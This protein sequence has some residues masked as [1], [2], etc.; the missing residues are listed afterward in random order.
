MAGE[1]VVVSERSARRCV[2]RSLATH[3]DGSHLLF[4]AADGTGTAGK[5][6]LWR[7]DGRKVGGKDPDLMAGPGCVF[8][9]VWS[10]WSNP[11][12]WRSL[13]RQRDSEGPGEIEYN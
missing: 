3:P 8:H 11:V 7:F 6:G 1:W 12:T 5:A 4:Q 13:V 10:P 9:A 2:H